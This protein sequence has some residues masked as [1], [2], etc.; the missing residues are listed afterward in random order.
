VHTQE[1]VEKRMK[2][3]NENDNLSMWKWLLSLCNSI[4]PNMPTSS[5]FTVY[6]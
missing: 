5:P 4:L 3:A 6:L 1:E 2:R